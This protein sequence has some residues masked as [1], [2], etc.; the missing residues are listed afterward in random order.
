MGY[1]KLNKSNI[2]KLIG[3]INNVKS[4][5]QKNILLEIATRWQKCDFNYKVSY[6]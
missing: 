1:R 6:F 3:S 5:V 4:N 2:E